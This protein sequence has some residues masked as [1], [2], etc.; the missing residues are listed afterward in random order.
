[1]SDDRLK[2]DVYMPLYVSDYDRDTAELS[3]EEHGFYMALLRALWTRGGE[4][5]GRDRPRLARVIRTDLET[6][7]R[8]W[9]AV[10]GFFTV[11]LAGKFQQKRLTKELNRAIESV[12]VM[13]EKTAA[14]GRASAAA[15]SR[16]TSVQT[17][18]EHTLNE[19]SNT[20]STISDLRSQDQISPSGSEGDSDP[21]R[22]P[23]QARDPEPRKPI[24]LG[25][26]TPVFLSVLEAY[27]NQNAKQRA[28]QEFQ[29]LAAQHGGEE[30][31]AIRLLSLFKRG[32]LK[33]HPY[34]GEPRYVP[35]LATMLAERRFEEKW[36]PPSM[37]NGVP[38]E[39]P[40]LPPG[41]PPPRAA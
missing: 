22:V 35:T 27:P 26:A 9:P 16:S 17:H 21:E 18:V 4:L 10:E 28:A 37:S 7:D 8:L 5:D 11:D 38:P 23:S 6:F 32:F 33:R 36:S 29:E 3:F 2:V 25:A 24:H 15:R 39:I 31:F 19:S 20:R 30:R 34:N 12:R 14:A 1:M 13:K 40:D 41:V